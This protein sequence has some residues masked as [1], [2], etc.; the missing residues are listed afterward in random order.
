[1]LPDEKH[2]YFAK[3]MDPE[4]GQAASVQEIKR[5]KNT[6]NGTTCI[7]ALGLYELKMSES[8]HK[9]SIKKIKG[10]TGCYSF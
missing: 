1:M 5:R 7:Q 3:K 6:L 2:H 8:F 9:K 10:W 4:C